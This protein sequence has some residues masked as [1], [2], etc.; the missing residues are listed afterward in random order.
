MRAS[1]N[2]ASAC[3]AS[4]LRPSFPMAIKIL[5]PGAQ[6]YGRICLNGESPGFTLNTLAERARMQGRS[7]ETHSVSPTTA[8]QWGR[9]ALD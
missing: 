6:L 3:C 9:G 2:T 8:C 7:F 1:L 5:G 4:P